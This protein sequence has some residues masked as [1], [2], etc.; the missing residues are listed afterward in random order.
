MR[1]RQGGF[2]RLDGEEFEDD[3]EDWEKQLDEYERDPGE[4]FPD[5]HKKA[6]LMHNAPGQIKKH[7]YLNSSRMTS[8]A[9]VKHEVVQFLRSERSF[10]NRTARKKDR[11]TKGYPMDIDEIGKGKK[12]KTKGGRGKG[13][14]MQ[15]FNS[16]NDLWNKGGKGRK[17]SWS[18]GGKGAGKG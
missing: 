2:V 1:F 8:F 17:S 3:V 18:K 12:G 5:N 4:I 15:H 10:E 11:N 13:G 7:L 9:V 6:I 14:K 16:W